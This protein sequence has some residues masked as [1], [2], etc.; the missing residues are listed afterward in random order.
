MRIALYGPFMFELAAGLKENPSNNVRLFL[1]EETLPRSLLAEP[2]WASEFTKA[3][4]CAVSSVAASRCF[5]SSAHRRAE[6]VQTLASSAGTV[7]GIRRRAV[8]EE[9]GGEAR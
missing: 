7:A 2:H 4:L 9:A 6:R 5:S 8:R 1:D 3:A